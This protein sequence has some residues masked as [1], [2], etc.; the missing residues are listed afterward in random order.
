[1]VDSRTTNAFSPRHAKLETRKAGPNTLRW[2]SIFTGHSCH[3]SPPNWWTYLGLV[4]VLCMPSMFWY[5]L[6]KSSQV[7]TS[8]Y[9]HK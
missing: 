8:T 2:V 3:R 4:L 1:M 6:V 5:F 7:G 9:L